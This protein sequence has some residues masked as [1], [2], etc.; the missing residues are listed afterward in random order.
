MAWCADRRRH[1]AGGRQN[2]DTIPQGRAS[3]PWQRG[4]K[5]R[6]ETHEGD[7]AGG[8]RPGPG[9]G[10]DLQFAAIDIASV[11]A[12]R[13]LTGELYSHAT[14]AQAGAGEDPDE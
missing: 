3:R 12:L 4:E 6:E 1:Q 9:E 11:A 14:Q 13:D 8:P 10:R 2:P 5:D 7:G